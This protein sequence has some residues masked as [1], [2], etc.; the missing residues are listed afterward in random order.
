MLPGEP[1]RTENA[2][3]HPLPVVFRADRSDLTPGD[4]FKRDPEL[5]TS[6]TGRD[7]KSGKKE[8]PGKQD[9][10]Y[11]VPTQETVNEMQEK[12]EPWSKEE[13]D[14]GWRNKNGNGDR[15]TK[16]LAAFELFRYSVSLYVD[17]KYG[18]D[19]EYMRGSAIALNNAYL[20]VK[21]AITNP[22]FP[23]YLKSSNGFLRDLTNFMTDGTIIS[24]DEKY[25]SLVNLW[26]NVLLNTG[27]SQISTANYTGNFEINI[28]IKRYVNSND[29][30]YY[31]TSRK[32]VI[33]SGDEV[34]NKALEALNQYKQSR[35]GG[36]VESD[37]E[38]AKQK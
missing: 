35:Q 23:E 11:N 18:D 22:T 36:R 3:G 33:P 13:A 38:S 2:N 6:L 31:N 32:L 26:G 29:N 5:Y 19:I 30:L 28:P 17:G 16:A 25:V 14:R 1:Q 9:F 21:D 37:I 34:L 8:L 10:L 15:S 27:S 20:N 24:G 4:V 12:A 7:A